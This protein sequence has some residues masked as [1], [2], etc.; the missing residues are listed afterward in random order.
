M[1]IATEPPILESLAREAIRRFGDRGDNVFNTAG[2]QQAV[3]H[4]TGT[5]PDSGPLAEKLD[6]SPRVVRLAGGCHWMLL[7][8]GH[9]K[10]HDAPGEEREWL[11][12]WGVPLRRPTPAEV[13]KRI[14]L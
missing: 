9:E 3:K 8:G 11:R 4:V 12:E 10:C 13:R 5:M 2:F 1:P 7:P 14:N 6:A